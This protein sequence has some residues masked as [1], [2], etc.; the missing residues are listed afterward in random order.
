MATT[1]SSR[2]KVGRM[3]KLWYY[4]AMLNTLEWL[5]N[6]GES[7]RRFGGRFESLY[8]K[9]AYRYTC[10]QEMLEYYRNH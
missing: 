3:L 5:T 7:Y 9:Y 10:Q 6:N 8:W 4:K 2:R 1:T